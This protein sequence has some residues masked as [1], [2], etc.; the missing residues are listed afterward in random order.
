MRAAAATP[1]P[2]VPTADSALTAGMVIAVPSPEVISDP[3]ETAVGAWDVKGVV[4]GPARFV[5]PVAADAPAMYTPPKLVKSPT[6]PL[7]SCAPKIPYGVGRL[8]MT[9]QPSGG[10]CLSL[11]LSRGYQAKRGVDPMCLVSH[12]SLY[13]SEMTIAWQLLR[14]NHLAI[15]MCQP[16]HSE[17]CPINISTWRTHIQTM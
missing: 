15:P 10:C 6:V 4:D 9:K 8:V 12:L 16:N 7:V 17:G 11:P 1:D 14:N 3:P 2:A 13:L 5:P